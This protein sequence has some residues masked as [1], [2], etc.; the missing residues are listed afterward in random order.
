MGVNDNL[1]YFERLEERRE[2]TWGEWRF[3]HRH[4]RVLARTARIEDPV[5]RSLTTIGAMIE[6]GS[7]AVGFALTRAF[8]SAARAKATR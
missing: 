6:A 7:A 2:L 8:R 5:I 3:L 1:G 4:R